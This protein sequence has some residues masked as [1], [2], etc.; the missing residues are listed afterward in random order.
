MIR[1]LMLFTVL[2]LPTMASAGFYKCKDASGHVLYSDAPCAASALTESNPKPPAVVTPTAPVATSAPAVKEAYTKD[3][4]ILKS[5]DAATKSCFTFH[6]TTAV[7][8]DPS[9]SKLLASRKKWVSVKDVGARQVVS[10]EVTSK[11]IAGMY[12]GKQSYD[13]LL[14]GDGVTVNT[15]PYD[16][17]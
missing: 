2:L 5:P 1:S 7:Y 3:V 14:M 17:L 15:K 8:P 10:I 11:N 9:T 13:C 4:P 16:L 12:V 6:N